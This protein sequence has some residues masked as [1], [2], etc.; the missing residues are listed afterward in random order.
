MGT[1]SS[2]DEEV[3]RESISSQFTIWTSMLKRSMHT[4]EAFDP[5]EYDIK[6]IRFLNEINSGVSYSHNLLYMSTQCIYVCT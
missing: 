1:K 5:D 6:Q 3:K 4:A 2:D